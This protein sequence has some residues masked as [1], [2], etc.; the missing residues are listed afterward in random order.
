MTKI[1]TALLMLLASTASAH[2]VPIEP[3]T[4]ALDVRLSAPD[5]SVAATVDP[6]AAG[7]LVRTSY[8]P[9]ANSTRSQM[10]VCPADPVDPS[11]RCALG[12]PARGFVVNGV[13]GS[14]GL[15]AAFALRLL[16]SGDLHAA[17]VPI[18]IGLGASPPVPVSFELATA[19]VLVGTT[20]VTGSPLDGGTG[21]VTIVGTG[22]SDQLPAPLGSTPLELALSCTLTPKPDLDQFALAARLTKVR[23][24]LT[25]KKA[26]L[27][28][29]LESEVT[30]P[31]D[32]VAEPTVLRLGPAD[33]ALLQ[34]IATLAA[35]PRG[36]FAS[37]DG[38]LLVKPMRSRTSRLMKIILKKVL[39]P[40]APYVSGQG[41]LALSSGGLAATRGVSLKANRRGTRLA[42]HEQ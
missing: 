23:G 33:A 30:M 14:I 3:S 17:S 20:A 22:T 26:K 41:S 39:A 10:Q 18:A 25:T 42:V 32:F 35:G 40:E 38:E 37:G 24:A 13:A 15:P 1:G 31:A 28:M 4:C 9:D 2:L 29:V 21:A 7:D 16:A 12:F 5:A 27:T 11:G 36:S 8:A 19:L 34:S 6:P